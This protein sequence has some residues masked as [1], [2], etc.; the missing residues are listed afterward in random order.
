MVKGRR[1][2]VAEEPSIRFTTH[3]VTAAEAKSACNELCILL[4][5]ATVP[6]YGRHLL[7][8]LFMPRKTLGY[9]PVEYCFAWCDAQDDLGQ[10]EKDMRS[11]N[12]Y[13]LPPFLI[14]DNHYPLQLHVYRE[15]GDFWDNDY[16]RKQNRNAL[17]AAVNGDPTTECQVFE[18]WVPYLRRAIK[19][20][21]DLA[22]FN[23]KKLSHPKSRSRKAFF[24]ECVDLMGKIKTRAEYDRFF[25]SYVKNRRENLA[26]ESL[27]LLKIQSINDNTAGKIGR[28]QAIMRD[29]GKGDK[30]HIRSM[31]ERLQKWATNL[32]PSDPKRARVI[33][34]AGEDLD[35]QPD[36]KEKRLAREK[37]DQEKKDRQVQAKI[38]AKIK[39]KPRPQHPKDGDTYYDS[40]GDLVQFL[41][42]D[43]T[44]FNENGEFIGDDPSEF[45]LICEEEGATGKKDLFDDSDD[46]SHTTLGREAGT[47]TENAAGPKGG[48]S[49]ENAAGSTENAAGPKDGTSTENAAGSTENAVGPK[50]GTS[51]ENALGDKTK[52]VASASD[53]F[54]GIPKQVV[55]FIAKV[56]SHKKEKPRD[57]TGR[58]LAINDVE[59]IDLTK[60]VDE[61]VERKQKASKRMLHS[62]YTADL[63]GP[64]PCKKKKLVFVPPK[65]QEWKDAKCY[66][67]RKMRQVMEDLCAEYGVNFKLSNIKKQQFAHPCALLCGF[68]SQPLE[69][70]LMEK[71]ALYNAACTFLPPYLA[72]N[73]YDDMAAL[74]HWL[75]KHTNNDK[76]QIE[77][78]RL[79]KAA[80]ATGSHSEDD[81][82]T[83]EIIFAEVVDWKK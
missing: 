72:S 9:E 17:K 67:Y 31:W 70:G 74:Y 20:C 60:D 34:I 7:K 28:V 65:D 42:N 50:D 23:A 71:T 25:S 5:P 73:F 22:I 55:A 58:L 24:G 35:E 13:T 27:D 1:Q 14:T 43:P 56:K 3:K 6:T 21:R 62:I 12:D 26:L 49:T 44:Y 30:G 66:Q 79:V 45:E 39:S 68:V 47:S 51:T 11:S 37:A 40:D 76:K 78:F 75:G 36:E 57:S 38:Q 80:I 10:I 52:E 82:T 15:M 16:A 41:C 64:K 19:F 46:D 2:A 61:V 4:Q 77:K 48:T 33:W 32:Q 59:I 54:T 81:K 83:L 69:D 63:C 29:L 8:A 53:D 18:Q